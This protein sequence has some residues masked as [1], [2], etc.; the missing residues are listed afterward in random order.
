MT[1]FVSGNSLPLVVDFPL[2]VDLPME[3]CHLLEVLVLLVELD[4]LDLQE[5]LVLVQEHLVLNFRFY[6]NPVQMSSILEVVTP[7]P[8]QWLQLE[9]PFGSK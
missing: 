5:S 2:V 4:P 1:A 6:Y 7:I 3:V 8:W 9:Q